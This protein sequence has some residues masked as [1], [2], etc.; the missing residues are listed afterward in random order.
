LPQTQNEFYLC[1]DFGIFYKKKDIRNKSE[2]IAL[3]IKKFR[4]AMVIKKKQDLDD[5][6]HWLARNLR[7]LI[8]SFANFVIVD[9]YEIMLELIKGELKGINRELE[10]TPSDA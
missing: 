10:L 2:I 4:D 9:Q 3:G 8:K 6:D 7:H 1:F 5:E